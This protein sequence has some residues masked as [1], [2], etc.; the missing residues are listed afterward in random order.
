MDPKQTIRANEAVGDILSGLGD[1]GLM[2]KYGLSQRGLERLLKKLMACGLITHDEVY[3]QSSFYREKIDRIMSRLHPR[4]NLGV[5]VPI[6]DVTSGNLGLVRDISEKGLRVAGIPAAVGD[7][8]TFQIPIDM[9]IHADPLLI[10]AECRWVTT[11]GK[12]RKYPVAGFELRDVSA[13]DG[14]LLKD[15]IDF[16]LLSKSGQWQLAQRKR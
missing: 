6:Y 4:A 14:K 16:L 5:K 12:N 2:E 11:K 7:E 1:N 10:I 3:R 9:F 8:R 13:H 15:F